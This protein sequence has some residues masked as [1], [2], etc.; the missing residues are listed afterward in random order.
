MAGPWEKYQEQ[1]PHGPWDKYGGQTPAP[2]EEPAA[3][4]KSW[5]QSLLEGNQNL[6]RGVARGAAG[7]AT[8]VEDI[9]PEGGPLGSLM[10]GLPEEART[11]RK[12]ASEQLHDFA[13]APSSGAAKSIGRFGGEVL[14]FLFQPELGIGRYAAGR[15]APTLAKLAERAV[16]GASGGFAQPTE[17]RTLESHA[18]NAELG[19]RTGAALSAIG[20]TLG[21]NIG[22]YLAGQLTRLG[23]SGGMHAAGAPGWSFLAPWLVHGGYYSPLSRYARMA[24]GGVGR[25]VSKL[26]GPGGAVTGQVSG[27]GKSDADRRPAE[28]PRPPVRPDRETAGRS[29]KSGRDYVPAASQRT[30]SRWS[31]PDYFRNTEEGRSP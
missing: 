14:P 17:G 24:A 30:D 28:S 5:G 4:K 2:A 19:A 29:G 26:A 20:G 10:P 13:T 27:G 1:Q 23:I 8:T 12:K 3:E 21:T 31:D 18:R 6:F 7:L 15:F 16:Q 22:R 11:A 25:G 9:L